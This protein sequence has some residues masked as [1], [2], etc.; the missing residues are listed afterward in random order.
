[1]LDQLLHPWFDNAALKSAKPISKG[2]NASPGAACG[3]IVFTAREAEEW[4]ARGEKV[5]LVRQDT[6]PEDI[7]GMA[8]SQG[9]LTSTGGMT[10][11]AA[12][13]ARGMGTP[14][15]AGAKGVSVQNKTAAIAGKVFNEGDWLSIDGS[16]GQIYEGKLP[17]VEPEIGKDM[18]TFLKWCDVVRAGAKRGSLKGFEVRT[19]A[20][21]PEDAKRAFEF[22]AQGVGLCRTEHMFFDKE[23]LIHFRAMIVADTVEG[24]KEALKKILPLQQQDFFGIFKAMEGRPVTIRLLDPPLH[25]FVPHTPEET[26]E[27]AQYIGV[28]VETLEPKIEKLREANPML[29]HRGCRLAVTYPE[30]YDMQVEAIALAAVDCVKQNISVNPEIMIP[31]VIS[32]RELKLLRPNAEAILKSVFDKAGVKLPVKIGT[33][34]EVPRAA[35]RAEHIAYY[36]DFFSFGTNDLTQMTFAFS[37]DDVAAFLPTYLEKN[38]LDVDPFKSIDEEG[39]GYLIQFAAKEG[40]GVNS[41]LKLGI[42]GEHGGDP[43]T[44]D[45]CYRSGLNYVSCSPFRVPLAR[46]AGA[47][48]VINNS[49]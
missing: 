1:L 30:I 28:S 22:G 26:L 42:C 15:V 18:S 21:Q 3:R 10:S 7:G 45:F 9:I 11:H 25:E 20:D 16:T 44:I 31:I 35:I 32:A 27:L 46:L 34:I 39:V 47:Q 8:V 38:V 37:R 12:V 36:A 48:A 40:R 49:R 19:N 13:V 17:L 5:L 33:M 6:S 4:H 23:K 24:R 43:A 14:C 2:L 29:G 41:T